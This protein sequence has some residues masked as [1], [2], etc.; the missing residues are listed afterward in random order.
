MMTI[1]VARSRVF[2]QVYDSN[3]R[4]VRFD[5]GGACVRKFGVFPQVYDSNQRQVRFDDGG[6][7]VRKFG[8]GSL[9][10]ETVRCVFSSFLTGH[11][12]C[13]CTEF[14][15]S[16]LSHNTHSLLL[17]HTH[18]HSLS[19]RYTHSYTQHTYTPMRAMICEWRWTHSSFLLGVYRKSTSHCD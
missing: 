11:T 13:P 17:T 14:F 15:V 12:H 9:V 4:Q 1:M 19:D 5:D 8:D 18:T 3:Q 10:C 2:P 6:A 7:C 16:H